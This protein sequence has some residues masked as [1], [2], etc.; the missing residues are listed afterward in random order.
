M[1]QPAKAMLVLAIAMAMSMASINAS[2]INDREEIFGSHEEEVAPNSRGSSSLPTNFPPNDEPSF[3]SGA[4]HHR[5]LIGDGTP[6]TC[7]RDPR[8][9]LARSSAGPFCCKKTCVDVRTDRLNCGLCGRKC[10]FNETCCSGN[11]VNLAWD[12]KNCGRCNKSCAARH[13]CAFGMCNYA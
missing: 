5:L 6:R 4:L 9:C 10:K 13:V 7:D 11:C 8:I 12:K 2:P 1:R 3:S